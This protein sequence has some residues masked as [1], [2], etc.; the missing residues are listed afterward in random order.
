MRKLLNAGAGGAVA[1]VLIIAS[2][3]PVSADQ[4]YSACAKD[5]KIIPGT[6]TVGLLS[7]CATG[8]VVSWNQGGPLGPMGATG[9]TGAA[10]ATGAVGATGAAGATGLPGPAGDPGAP[11]AVG[12][13]GPAGPKGTTG[14]MGPAG[15]GLNKV[16]VGGTYGGV[17]GLGIYTGSGF[18]IVQDPTM[19]SRYTITFPAGTW[20]AY[21]VATF[22][23]FFG[24]ATADIEFA[25]NDG[26]VW[27][28]NWNTGQSTVFN[29]TFIQ[30]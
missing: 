30:P 11:G 28:I 12:P 10:G 8:V 22:Q 26:L 1:A 13:T 6:L 18:T 19:L 27:T 29:F 4:I 21:P 23:S 2:W 3:T 14:A 20:T 24:T 16:I 17:S 7:S 15:A 9:A 25:S 5:G